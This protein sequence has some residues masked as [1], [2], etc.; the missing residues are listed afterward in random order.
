MNKKDKFKRMIKRAD[1]AL[2]IA[3]DQVEEL[4]EYY[5]SHWRD[6]DSPQAEETFGTKKLY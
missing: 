3:A 2:R 5:A 1:L 6:D 4:E